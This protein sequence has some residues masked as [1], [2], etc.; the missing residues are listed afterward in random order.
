MSSRG[1]V[2]PPSLPFALAAAA[3][4]RASAINVY[5]YG[6]RRRKIYSTHVLHFCIWRCLGMTDSS[7]KQQWKKCCAINIESTHTS[8]AWAT[9]NSSTCS[10]NCRTHKNLCLFDLAAPGAG[11]GV[12]V[13]TGVEAGV[14]CEFRE[15]RLAYVAPSGEWESVRVWRGETYLKIFYFILIFCTR[16]RMI[17][18]NGQG[19]QG[20]CKMRAYACFRNYF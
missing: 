8:L 17:K 9:P 20:G 16:A 15:L 13:G 3:C 10:S 14:N 11:T 1:D 5:D 2:L 6:Q 18:F 19:C 12:G 4:R 7:Y